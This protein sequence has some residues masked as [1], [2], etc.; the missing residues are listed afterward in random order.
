MTWHL[1]PSHSHVQFSVRHMMVSTVKGKF[2]S[3]TADAEVELND[4]SSARVTASADVSS[5]HT[6]EDQRDGHL[7]SP[8]FLDAQN[9]PQITLVTRTVKKTGD[10]VE[11]VGDLTIRG[12]TRPVTFS[13]E[14]FGPAKDPWGGQRMGLNLTGEIDREDFGLTWNQALE[15]GGFL[16]GKKVKIEL[17]AEFVQK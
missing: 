16:V 6:G 15:T 13:G 17:D 5:L 1:D 10:A 12:T 2:T 7:K 11:V 3:F 4:L 9:H 14:I 8:D